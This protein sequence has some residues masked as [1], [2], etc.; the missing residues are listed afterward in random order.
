MVPGTEASTSDV[1][2]Q[3]F[4]HPNHFIDR[5]IGLRKQTQHHT[6]PFLY[7]PS[8]QAL[9]TKNI[10]QS[11]C[12]WSVTWQTCFTHHKL[13]SL[14]IASLPLSSLGPPRLSTSNYVLN[15]SYLVPWPHMTPSLTSHCI[16]SP[17]SLSLVFKALAADLNSI[18]L[19]RK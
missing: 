1:I 17:L 16:L 19:S 5:W 3:K 14:H 7:L 6:F 10:P 13:P 11:S 12:H 15:R 18:I 8:I 4:L 2:N 9:K